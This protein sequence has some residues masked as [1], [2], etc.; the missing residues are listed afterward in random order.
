MTKLR[1]LGVAAV[2]LTG[3]AVGGA[4]A[5]FVVPPAS[6][7]QPPPGAT[8]WEYFCEDVP[9]DAVAQMNSANTWGAQYWELAQWVESTPPSISLSHSRTWCFKRPRA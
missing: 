3:C 1:S 4:S 8:R 5:R 2:F 6:A 9:S 7:Q